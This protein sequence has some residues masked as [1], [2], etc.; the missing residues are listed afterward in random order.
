M[1]LQSTTAWPDKTETPLPRYRN[2]CTT[3]QRDAATPMTP[4]LR[5]RLQDLELHSQHELNLP[6][7]SGA[8]VRRSGVVIVVVEVV[9]GVDYAEVLARARDKCLT[10]GIV[11]VRH[12]I[13][14]EVVGVAKLDVIQ[15][16]KR[17]NSEL[18]R[19]SLRQFSL[20]N[21]RQVNLPRRQRTNDPVS[22]IPKSSHCAR[23]TGSASHRVRRLDGE[24]LRRSL[25]RGRIDIRN[26]IFPAARQI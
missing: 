23:N 18:Q 20:F 6:R 17:L 22:R 5:A 16:I 25:K 9:G 4:N 26:T 3:I 11:R 19:K 21:E 2:S 24:V 12:V 15:D 13:Q 8:G 7:Q 14:R 10:C 1:W